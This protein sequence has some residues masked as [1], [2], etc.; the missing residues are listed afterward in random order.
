MQRITMFKK[1]SEDF[2]NSSANNKEDSSED[3]FSSEILCK[4]LP[5]EPLIIDPG[6]NGSECFII[7]VLL[8]LP[9]WIKLSATIVADIL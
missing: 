5:S 4:Q 1:T 2:P 3:L 6:M 9:M 8:P 7:P